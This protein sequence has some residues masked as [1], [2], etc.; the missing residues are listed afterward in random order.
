[1]APYLSFEDGFEMPPTFLIASSLIHDPDGL[2]LTPWDGLGRRQLDRRGQAE[3]FLERLRDA[4]LERFVGLWLLLRD[5]LG[6]LHPHAQFV[7]VVLAGA[8]DQLVVGLEPLDAEQGV[9]D[10]RGEKVHPAYDEHVV[11]AS[12]DPGDASAGPSAG[13]PL[14]GKPGEISGA[15]PENGERFLSRRGKDQLAD[16]PVRQGLAGL[17]VHYLRYKKIL[18]D[19]HPF[20]ATAGRRDARADDLREAVLFVDRDTHPVLDLALHLL[21]H[22][23][24]AQKRRA[25]RQRMWIHLLFFGDLGDVERVRG[26]GAERGDTE[27]A[28]QHHLLRGVSR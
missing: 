19:V 6:H 21:R 15:V 26:R 7:L 27:V 4:G 1:M 12:E 28:H 10:L 13:A 18:P 22:G 17:R 14:A 20:R 2:A 24:G 23:L 3:G 9:L 11:R 25:N 5:V 16:L 8:E